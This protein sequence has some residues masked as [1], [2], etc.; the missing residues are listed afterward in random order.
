M[1]NYYTRFVVTKTE[2]NMQQNLTSTG[3]IN[4][5]K[6]QQE[7]NRFTKGQKLYRIF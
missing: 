1:S 3:T 4:H 7:I 6:Q 5:N 2:V